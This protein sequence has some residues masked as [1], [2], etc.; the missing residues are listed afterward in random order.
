MILFLPLTTLYLITLRAFGS[1]TQQTPLP[2]NCT[3]E[4]IQKLGSEVLTNILRNYDQ[5]LVPNPLGVDV[6]IELI[7]QVVSE[8]SEIS[9]SFKSDLLYSQIWHDPALRFD[10]IT[11]C[12][13]NLTLSHK[14]MD[15]LWVPNVCFI[16]SK[17]T[18]IHSSP[19]P[20]V[21]LLI[22]PNGTVWTNYRVAIQAPCDMEFTAFPM[23]EAKCELLFESYSFNVGKVRTV[24]ICCPIANN[25]HLDPIIL[26]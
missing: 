23:D 10:H 12:L 19:T 3:L 17:K 5:N 20:N 6:E 11:N 1:P 15:R 24:K 14:M 18:E 7:M 16:N 25:R 2:S 26:A 4:E 13:T 8:I 22:F 21:F 9:Y